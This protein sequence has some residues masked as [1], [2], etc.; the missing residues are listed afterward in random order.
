MTE[1]VVKE[2]LLADAGDEDEEIEPC[3]D[4]STW[5]IC[6]TCSGNGKHSRA[7]GAYSMEDF[8]HQFSPDEQAEYFA[9]GYDSTCSTCTGSGKIR[10]SQIERHRE[11]LAQERML[12]RGVNDAGERLW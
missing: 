6:P 12:E 10:E 8:Q 9:G 2:D 1:L 3:P 11:Y 4:S 5:M 7:L